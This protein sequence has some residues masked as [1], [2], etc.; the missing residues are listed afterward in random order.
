M[1]LRI[2]PQP[3]SDEGR[4]S[5]T[6][7]A[8]RPILT[9]I[10][11]EWGCE[12]IPS[13]E[14]L[15]PPFGGKPGLLVLPEIIFRKMGILVASETGPGGMAITV[16]RE[17]DATTWEDFLVMKLA[18]TVAHEFGAKLYYEEHPEPMGVEPERFATFEHYVETVLENEDDLVR[19]MKRVWMY[20]HRKRA[21]R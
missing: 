16:E 19:E 21:V 17:E 10:A 8:V 12:L 13:M 1:L 11:E 18:H 4:R 15:F 7:D 9:R 5:L 6:L 20:T 3:G 14:M 2:V